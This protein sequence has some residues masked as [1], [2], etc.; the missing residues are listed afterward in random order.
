MANAITNTVTRPGKWSA[1][2]QSADMVLVSLR[3]VEEYC[4]KQFP[5]SEKILTYTVDDLSAP[6]PAPDNFVINSVTSVVTDENA[7]EDYIAEDKWIYPTTQWSSTPL[8]VTLTGGVPTQVYDAI[9]R[10]ARVLRVR[11][12]LAPEVSDINIPFDM[13]FNNAMRSGLAPDVKSMIFPFRVLG[14]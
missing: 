12:D 4:A 10:Q 2:Q 13:K 7:K 1:D 8:T 6:L 9:V 11:S 14:F 5:L 3:M